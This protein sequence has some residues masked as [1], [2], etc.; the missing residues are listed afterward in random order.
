MELDLEKKDVEMKEDS[1][2]SPK[3]ELEESKETS[4]EQESMEE[5]N[6]LAV[7]EKAELESDQP[8]VKVLEPENQPI[9]TDVADLSPEQPSEQM[10]V[11]AETQEA[12]KSPLGSEMQPG[13]SNTEA[14]P[15]SEIPEASMP[16]EVTAAPADPSLIGTPS[17]DEEE[18]VSD[19]ESER[20]QE[21][22]VTAL[23]ISGMAARLLESWKDLKVRHAKKYK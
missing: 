5:H 4:E 7:T 8:A 20:S 6:S 10:E 18:G 13:E 15:S 23:D 3:D 12:E 14:P 22:Q 19:V 9:Q 2:E 21:P 17:Q 1:S 16:S 11:Q